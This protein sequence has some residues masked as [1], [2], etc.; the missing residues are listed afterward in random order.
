[1]SN[2]F[3]S[4]P[5]TTAPIRQDLA[6]GFGDDTVGIKIPDGAR[7]LI[8]FDSPDISIPGLQDRLPAMENRTG[9]G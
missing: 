5:R 8:P 4:K 3:S 9:I 7:A 2:P 6:T 1:M